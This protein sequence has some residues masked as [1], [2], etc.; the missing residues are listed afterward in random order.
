MPKTFP[1]P[2]KCSAVRDFPRWFLIE[3]AK[4]STIFLKMKIESLDF[5]TRTQNAIVDAGVR[6]LGGLARKKQQDLL[7]IEGLGEKGLQEIK[8]V[9][10]NYGI[11]LK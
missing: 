8:R 7:S 4:N 1:V 3:T 9:L 2:I 5:S 10:G 11:V 6:T